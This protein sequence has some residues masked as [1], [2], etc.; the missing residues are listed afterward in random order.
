[1]LL[2]IFWNPLV[3]IPLLGYVFV[4]F[5]DSSIK[6]RSIYIGWLSVMAVFVQFFGYGIGFAKSTFYSQGLKSNPQKQ[7]PKLFFD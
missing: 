1:V 3:L 5:I 2:A 4:L 7:F 6:N